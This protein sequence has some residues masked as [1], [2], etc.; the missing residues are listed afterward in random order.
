MAAL[1]PLNI[2]YVPRYTSKDYEAWEGRWEI[3]E[4]I[5][6]AMSPQ[7]SIEHQEVSGNIHSQLKKLLTQ[8][9]ACRALLPVDWKIDDTT[10]VQPDNL[11]IC[12]EAG[13]KYL[14]SPPEMIFEIVS[15]SSVF[16]D[17]TIKYKIY[18]A[19]GVKFYIIVDIAAK[20]AE[21]F[22]LI[23]GCYRKLADAQ[24]GV[25]AFA[26]SGCRMDFDFAR[27]W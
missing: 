23:E 12:A 2:N 16:K 8:C 26:L 3:I 27:I 14:T 19:Q 21:V 22:E 15:P 24:D 11:V 20:V 4:G 13:G 6:H 1:K 9:G 25:V 10:V 7:P 18:E 5:A 17:K